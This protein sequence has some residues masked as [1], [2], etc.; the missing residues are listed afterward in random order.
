VSPGH[1]LHARVSCG[2]SPAA[3]GVAEGLA[4]RGFSRFPCRGMMI[5][6][7]LSRTHWQEARRSILSR[8]GLRSG[9]IFDVLDARVLVFEPRL[10]DEPGDLARAARLGPRRSG[11]SLIFSSN[12][13][14][15]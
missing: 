9:G 6:V 14:W 8:P 15:S 3:C 7:S 2:D 13:T 11:M 10:P 12:P 5:R 1:V 4:D